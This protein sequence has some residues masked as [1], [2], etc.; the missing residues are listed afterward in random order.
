MRVIYPG[1]FDPITLGHIDV[2]QRSSSLFTRVVWAVAQSTSKK[3]MLTLRQRVLCAQRVASRWRNVRVVSFEGLLKNFAQEQDISIIVRGIRNTLDMQVEMQLAGMNRSL[4]HGLET[5]F[6]PCSPAW[7][8]VSSTIVR[9]LIVHGNQEYL[10]Y[11]PERT[12]AL[13]ALFLKKESD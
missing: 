8:Y 6:L 13:L 5:L 12:H 4:A 3:T 7:Q 10:E 9:D 11:V 1:T 2:L